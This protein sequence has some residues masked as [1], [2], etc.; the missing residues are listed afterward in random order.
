MLDG[1]WR[2]SSKTYDVT[3]KVPGSVY[4]ALLAKGLM[5]DP[6]Y[7]DNEGKALKIMDEEFEFSRKF[8]YV[9]ES[10]SVLLVFEGIDTLG[11]IFLNGKLVG[12]VDNMFR[13]YVFEVADYLLDGENEIKVVF[14]P[15]DEYISA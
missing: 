11:D 3:G 4:S 10:K 1:E 6:F 9:K 7:R 8:I 15:Y 2:I 14:P 5:E 12:H 13:K